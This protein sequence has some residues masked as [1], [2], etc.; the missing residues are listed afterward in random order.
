MQNSTLFQ[1]PICRKSDTSSSLGWVWLDPCMWV[2][3]TALIYP[4]K[5]LYHNSDSIYLVWNG[6]QLPPSND[7]ELINPKD[8]QIFLFSTELIKSWFNLWFIRFFLLLLWLR[9][10][11][12]PELI[13]EL[14]K[15]WAC[16]HESLVSYVDTCLPVRIIKNVWWQ[17]K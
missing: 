10:R 11:M 8:W 13:C 9:K 6:L 14:D 7:Y 2:R 5:C 12:T 1:F 15:H 3:S 17:K 16:L 4:M